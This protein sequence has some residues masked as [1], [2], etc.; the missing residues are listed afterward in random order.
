M[1]TT[2]CIEL[3]WRLKNRNRA[4]EFDAI[5]LVIADYFKGDFGYLHEQQEVQTN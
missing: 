3:A 1:C 2:G 5:K 4:L